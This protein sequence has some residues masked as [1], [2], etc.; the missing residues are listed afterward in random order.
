M[1]L[2]EAIKEGSLI[3]HPELNKTY[4]FLGRDAIVELPKNQSRLTATQKGIQMALRQEMAETLTLSVID[5]V[6]DDWYII[7]E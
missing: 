5:I 4:F 2:I 1:T 3:S 6:R 7:T